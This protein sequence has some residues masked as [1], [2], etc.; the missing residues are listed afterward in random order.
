VANKN[1]KQYFPNII[2]PIKSTILTISLLSS[3]KNLQMIIV[4]HLI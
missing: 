3:A 4:L 1:Y 2:F